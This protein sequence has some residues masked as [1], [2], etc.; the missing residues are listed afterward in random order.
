VESRG[1]M[2]LACRGVAV[3]NGGGVLTMTNRHK[4]KGE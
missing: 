2:L 1:V 4:S 3:E